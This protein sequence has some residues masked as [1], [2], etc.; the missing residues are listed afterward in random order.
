MKL[1]AGRLPDYLINKWA[2]VLYSIR[3]KG[4]NPG[5]KDLAKFVKR[6]AA[7]KNDPGFAGV[8]AMP[9]T[10]TRGNRKKPPNSTNGSPNPRHTSSF[11][12][13]VAAKDTGRRPGT[14]DGQS[15][16]QPSVQNC[17]CCSGPHELA[18]CLELQNKDLQSR[19]DVVKRHRLC[20]V[21]MRSG[22][23]RGRCEFRKFF[24][25]GSNKRHHRL[26]HNPPRINIRDTNQST[27]TR[28]EEVKSTD[29][30]EC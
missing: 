22:H 20:H 24:P 28:E 6:Q 14:G 11:L 3:R 18:S 5:L 29:T 23:H 8:V 30:S 25:C 1:I 16:P 12:T 7:I 15:K 17:L 26:L 2:D 19:W 27:Q 13:D 4:E 10:E 9:T 21:C